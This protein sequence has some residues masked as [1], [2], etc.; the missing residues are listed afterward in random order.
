MMGGVLITY[1]LGLGDLPRDRLG[2]DR[3]VD[4]C[5]AGWES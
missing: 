2:A 1:E 3:L 4:Y 5:T